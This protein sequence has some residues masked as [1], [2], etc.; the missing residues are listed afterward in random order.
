MSTRFALLA[1][2]EQKP[3]H[4]YDLRRRFENRIG[5]HWSLNFGQVYLT[6]EALE[7]QRLIKHEVVS[8]SDAPDRKL[9]T[10]T[11]EGLSKLAEWYTSPVESTKG[12]KDEF[13]LKLVL[14]FTTKTASIDK[15]VDK[16]KRFCLQKLHELTQLKRQAQE[17][18]DIARVLLLD[19]V[20]FRTEAE[21]RWLEM[22]EERIKD[23][24]TADWLPLA[25]ND[26]D[27]PLEE[28]EISPLSTEVK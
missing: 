15:I 1:L 12:L 6:L 7:K 21:L 13:Y 18:K 11:N 17:A 8:G 27:Q 22:T 2:L 16:Q 24:V 19:L 28:Y 10:I 14:G 3:M 26:D 25:V 9:Y 5:N 23:L 20:V 4:G